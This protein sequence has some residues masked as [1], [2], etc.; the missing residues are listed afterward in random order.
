MIKKSIVAVLVGVV[1]ISSASYAE[2]ATSTTLTNIQHSTD[3]AMEARLDSMQKQINDLQ[4]V[5]ESLQNEV[6][7]NKSKWQDYIHLGSSV[8]VKGSKRNNNTPRSQG[9]LL[10]LVH[11]DSDFG[12]QTTFGELPSSLMPLS[13]QQ[14]KNKFGGKETGYRSLVF[15][16]YLEADPQGWWGSDFSKPT[17]PGSI[18][19]GRSYST[20]AYNNGGGVFLTTA[21]LYM[22]ANVNQWTQAFVSIS[23]SQNSLDLEQA[24]VTFGNLE[25]FPMFLTLGKSRMPFGVFAGGGAWVSGITQGLFRPDHNENIM[26]SYSHDGLNT[27]LVYFMPQ[28]NNG[29]LISGTTNAESTNNNYQGN[30]M[31]SAFYHG[32]I[33]KTGITYGWNFGYL[34][35]MANSGIGASKQLATNSAGTTELRNRQ[36]RNSVLNF[37]GNLGY[38]DYSLFAGLTTTAMKRSYTNGNR[39]GAW[40]IQANYSPSI[41]I[42]GSDKE[43]VFSIAY[44]G[45][46]NT[47]NMPMSLAGDAADGISVTGVQSEIV[48]FVQR[49]VFD[50]VFLGL[51][52]ARLGMYDGSHSNEVTLDTSVYF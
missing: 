13:L 6:K 41:D 50:H 45:A 9:S 19:D 20:E 39:A 49:E 15:G 25:K 10:S 40:Y 5:N 7:E 46:Y 11:D 52:Y 17:G 28:A 4:G 35:N 14:I 3:A 48:T 29:A 24:F 32:K 21:S 26:L 43:T 31:Y 37:E 30:F 51:E 36:D 23:G 22:M 47:Q 8:G 1:G 34:Y 2:V 44:N 27:N 38:Q 12:G 16:G 42:F 33:A 18:D